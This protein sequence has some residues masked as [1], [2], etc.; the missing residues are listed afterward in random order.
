MFVTLKRDI[1]AVR[2]RDPAAR[3]FLEIIFCYPGLHALWGYRVSHFLWK[4]KLKLVARFLSHLIRWLTGIEIHPGAVIGP[5][6][7]I[8]HGMGVVIGETAEVGADVTLFQG[9]TLGGKSWQKGKRH[10]TLG[11]GVVVGAGAKV[12]GS[13]SVGARARIGANAVVVKEVPP[14]A[15]VVGVP[16]EVLES[17]VK[18]Q[19]LETAKSQTDQLELLLNRIKFLEDRLKRDSTDSVLTVTDVGDSKDDFSI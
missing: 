19:G 6:F 4:I 5:G 3:S 15:I 10:P 18:T 11:D 16:G 17:E 14:D 13:F 12:L 7:F 1:Q 8:D 2:S 9:V